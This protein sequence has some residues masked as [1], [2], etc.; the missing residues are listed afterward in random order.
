MAFVRP[1]TL[2]KI[3]CRLLNPCSG[4]GFSEDQARNQT[5]Q[6]ALVDVQES[7]GIVPRLVMVM[8][9]MCGDVL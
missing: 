8:A 1:S 4:W 6:A 3:S 7:D 5:N 2:L 9:W